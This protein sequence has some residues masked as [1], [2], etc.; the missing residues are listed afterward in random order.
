V[1][2]MTGFLMLNVVYI[3]SYHKCVCM[4]VCYIVYILYNYAYLIVHKNLCVYICMRVE[5]EQFGKGQC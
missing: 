5:S 2:F 1:C 3:P 4:H